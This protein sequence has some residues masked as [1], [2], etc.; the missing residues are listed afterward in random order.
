MFIFNAHF[1]FLFKILNFKILA[2]NLDDPDM[3][4]A[5]AVVRDELIDAV[6]ETAADEEEGLVVFILIWTFVKKRK[7]WSKTEIW[8]LHTKI[9]FCTWKIRFLTKG[10]QWEKNES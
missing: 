9:Q 6:F 8:V 1:S 10:I 3:A 5:S 2:G 7:I 4:G